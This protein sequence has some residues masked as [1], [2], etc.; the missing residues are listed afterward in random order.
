MEAN[1]P[2]SAPGAV[3]GV[4]GQ[5]A[6][7]SPAPT[8]NQPAPQAKN[9][10]N[11]SNQPQIDKPVETEAPKAPELYD[12][13]INGQTRKY[14]L[15]QLRDKAS[16]SEAAMERFEEASKLSKKSQGF[17]ENLKKDFM[18]A[19]MD[20]ELGLSK[21]QIRER[22]EN[23]YKENYI[24][25]EQMTHEQRRI[26]ELEAREKERNE[27]E[28]ERTQ[29]EQAEQQER[30]ISAERE[31]IQRSIIDALETSDLPKNRFTVGRMA[32]WQ[33]QNLIR[34]FDAPMEVIV[35][36]VRQERQDIVRSEF[37]GI[38][39]VEQA[40]DLVGEE[41]IN[42]LRKF[43][44]ERLK[45]RFNEPT[46]AKPANNLTKGGARPMADVDAYF[47]NLRRSKR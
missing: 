39:S 21:D 41:F 10:R 37:Q 23:W 33:K 6:V 31:T 43:D 25:P 35:G 11:V 15:Q 4:P 42:M 5:T 45:K 29:R 38:K 13:T 20:P 34:G 3:P 19:L 27:K 24:D 7:R 46:V 14:T 30:G 1:T 36:Q 40:I 47:N 16:L 28:A 8:P 2:V 32:Y 44:V 22:F 9:Q 18:K 17:Q 26:R 12:V